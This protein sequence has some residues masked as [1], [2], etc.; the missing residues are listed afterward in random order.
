MGKKL[1]AAVV[2]FLMM[3]PAAV[4]A[5]SGSVA[6]KITDGV[7]GEDLPGA[8]VYLLE[9]KRG[10]S[11]DING[12]Y[13]IPNVPAGTYTVVAS[14][15]GY[16]Q[17][18]TTVDVGSSEVTLDIALDPDV[19]GLEDVVV[20]GIASRSSKAVA[21]V[22]ISRIEA[23][24]LT[25]DKSY[26]DLSQVLTG[27]VAGVNVQAASGNVG[28]GI[29]FNIRS[30]GGLNGNGQPVIFIDGVRIDNAQIA[31]TGV[32]GQGVGTLADLNP[33]DIESIDVLK[34][35]AGAAL[36]GTSGSNGV[37][38]IT[39]KKGKTVAG[40]GTVNVNLKQ[41]VGV[42]DQ[43]VE[44]GAD[45]LFTYESV[46]DIIM[47]G[48]VSQSTVSVNG[49]SDYIRYFTQFDVTNE[50]GIV[51]NNKMERQSFRANFDVFPS[52]KVT[53]NVNAG[54]TLNETNLPQNDNNILG[55]LGNNILAF[56]SGA[57]GARTHL[58][59]FFTDSLDIARLTD[60]TITNRFIG[61]FQ[62][63][64]R[65]I[66]GLSLTAGV[67]YD[68]SDMRQ[69]QF[70]PT[71]STATPQV[72]LR[73]MYARQNAQFTW[74]L[75]ARYD[76]KF[77]DI[78]SA[79]TVGTQIFSRRFRDLFNSRQDFPSNEIRAIQSGADIT[80]LSEDFFNVREAGIFFQEE[81]N[82]KETFFVTAGGRFDY[83]S[84]VGDEAAS[85][86]YPKL[87]AAVRLDQMGILPDAINFFKLRAAYGETGILPGLTAGE[88]SL[89]AASN[90]GFGIGAVP[91]VIGNPEI[92]PE[93]IRELEFGAEITF[94]DN[95]GV[96]FT[97]YIQN[98]DDSI[99][100]FNAAPSTG[101]V[102]TSV[103]LNVGSIE[104][105]GIELAVNATPILSKNTQLDLTVIWSHQ[106][107]E[108]TDL[109]GAQPI[110]DGF[111]VNTIEE[112]LARSTF[113]VTEIRGATYDANG[114]F[115]GLD[116][117]PGED[118]RVALGIPYPEDQFSASVNFRFLKNFNFYALAEWQTGLT[119]YNGTRQF[120]A[121]LARNDPEYDELRG[122][123]GFSNYY[124]L[125]ADPNND[126]TPLTPGT[127]EYNEAADR[128]AVLGGFGAT[129]NDFGYIENADFMR[130]REVSLS[131]NFTD[132]IKSAG[133]GKTIKTMNFAVSGRNLFLKSD[134][135]ADPEIN[136]AGARSLTRG[137]DFLTLQQPKVYNAT[138]S[139]GF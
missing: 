4:F 120:S 51:P 82:F 7:T 45:D 105:S 54:F 101:R 18:K 96:D 27:K 66:E 134:Y 26:Q 42:N 129:T 12:T 94:L 85:I 92:E 61:S 103:P 37:V 89:W 127:P 123:L 15:L 72:G 35:P 125:D 63:N 124:N 47:A 78:N 57:A 39:T 99:I 83:A 119:L 118:G 70:R 24:D 132:I 64:W 79:T 110:R 9:I 13:N 122:L 41:R 84:S 104:G 3:V 55:W 21:E 86:F 135:W 69:D 115:L 130:I 36:Y 77:G 112:G 108:V 139:I 133:L 90:S 131:Y 95:F 88:S 46:N 53:F 100:G 137:W 22:A 68:G 62:L 81:I 49:G 128:F 117:T 33:E 107:N 76:A 93:R 23:S 71:N 30:G 6:G 74:D 102:A 75:N 58:T 116:N 65:P 67:G 1:L 59:Y 98:A 38:L 48:N 14:F 10:A 31:G 50:E 32:G 28:G 56:Q 80:A 19:V 34:G 11:S 126:I 136:G 97:Y 52:D 2:L 111:D 40:K 138:L 29:R 17:F 60:E 43:S 73:Q 113:F 5:Q 91:S 20:T 121:G 8:N 25:L 44:Y 109:G 106:T 16:K 114:A 87:S